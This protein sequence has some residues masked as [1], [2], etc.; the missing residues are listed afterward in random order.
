[1]AQTLLECGYTEALEH[2]VKKFTRLNFAELARTYGWSITYADG[3]AD[4]EAY[5][6]RRQ[7]PPG[8]LLW[9][10]DEYSQGFQAGYKGDSMATSRCELPAG[11]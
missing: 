3:Y 4:G 1:M 11:S 9:G 10:F 2:Q 8:Y 5:R 6:A 7:R